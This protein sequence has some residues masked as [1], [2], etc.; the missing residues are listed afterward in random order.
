VTILN[1]APA[2]IHLDSDLF[3][4]SDVICPNETEAELLTG[5]TVEHVE[6]AGDAVKVLLDQGC[7]K[8]II[9][10]GSHGA[11]YGTRE[12]LEPCHVLAEAVTPVDTTGAGDAF[13][14]SLAFYLAKLPELSFHEIVSRSCKVAAISVQRPGTQTSFPRRQELPDVLFVV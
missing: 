12:G 2:E 4:Y 6:D 8:V 11:V 14:G 3:K 13:I 7:K 10:M 5:H 1:P 9:T